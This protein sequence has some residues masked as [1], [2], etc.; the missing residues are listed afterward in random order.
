MKALREICPK[1]QPGMAVSGKTEL[2]INHAL[3]KI[4]P[5]V[6]TLRPVNTE[7]ET[8]FEIDTEIDTETEEWVGFLL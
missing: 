5:A 6:S 3:S 1:C 7:P 4:A 8:T 2:C